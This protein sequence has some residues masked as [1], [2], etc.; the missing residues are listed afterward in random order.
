[1]DGWMEMSKCP[2]LV[3]LVSGWFKFTYLPPRLSVLACSA[4]SREEQVQA[5]APG[6]PWFVND[7]LAGCW[8]V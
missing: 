4:R 6:R 7:C 1:M 2:T 5:P 8:P 3:G